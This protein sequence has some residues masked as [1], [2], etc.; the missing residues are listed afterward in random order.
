MSEG[1]RELDLARVLC[2][3]AQIPDGGA[4]GFT[5][6][7]GDWPLRGVLVR[8]GAAVWGYV[9]RCPHAGHPLNLKPHAFLTPDDALILCASHGALFDK[10]SGFCLA[11]PCTGKSLTAVPLEL[12]EGYVL[13]A[14][15]FDPLAAAARDA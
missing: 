3:L 1:R 15:G 6:G 2:A 14:Q 11:G 7:E 4:R 8:T 12:A 5:V 9:N 10:Q 13:L